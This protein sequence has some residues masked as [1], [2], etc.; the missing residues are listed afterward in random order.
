MIK[1]MSKSWHNSL[2]SNMTKKNS[3]PNLVGNVHGP[4]ILVG[5]GLDKITC[6]LKPRTL[7]T[8]S[9]TDF[10]SLGY[11]QDDSAQ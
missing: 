7:H 11:Y 9:R 2:S 6:P 5:K 4:A 3:F 8:E 10:N 1:G